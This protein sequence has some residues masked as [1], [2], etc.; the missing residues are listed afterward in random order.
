MAE[1]KK[2]EVRLAN[3]ER[4]IS[5][6]STALRPKV[7]EEKAAKEDIDTYLRVLRAALAADWGDFCGINDCFKC[8]H[9][10]RICSGGTQLCRACTVC[11]ICDVECTCGPCAVYSGA[12][13]KKR[14]AEFEKLK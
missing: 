11:L 3:I 9:I 14:T 13:V 1:T 10:C 6:L 8:I 2:L 4:K 12:L 7:L 5:E